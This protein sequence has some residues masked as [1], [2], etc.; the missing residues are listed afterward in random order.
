LERGFIY[1]PPA[2]ARPFFLAGL[3]FAC[4]FYL[5]PLA[6]LFKVSQQ[7]G[8]Y[9]PRPAGWLS[10]ARVVLRAYRPTLS[11]CRLWRPAGA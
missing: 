9:R 2:A 7:A 4:S 1:L 6:A 3:S 8:P 10:V 11:I 5:P